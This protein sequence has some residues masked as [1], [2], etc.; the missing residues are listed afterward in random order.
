MELLSNELLVLWGAFL[1]DK[2]LGDPVQLPH[3]IVG[4]GKLIAWFNKKFNK[5]NRRLAKGAAV[6]A[7]LLLATFGSFNFIIQHAYALGNNVGVAVEV[8]CVFFGLAG[9]TLAREGKA[10]FRALHKS[11]DAGRAQVSRIVGRDTSSLSA[12]EVKAA[13]LETLAE[14][15]SDGVIAPLF[16]FTIAGVPGIM[17]Y[18]M[19][20]TLDSMIGYKNEKYL[21][22]GKVAARVDDFANFI[23][24]R[25]TAL[26]MAIC[27]GKKRSFQFIWKYGSAHSSPNAGY[28]E[29]ALAGALH[30]QFGGTHNYFGKPVFKPFIGEKKRS[31]TA[32]DL[33]Q[34][35]RIMRL[36]EFLFMLL[37]SIYF[38]Y[39]YF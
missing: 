1:L 26:L 37:I 32:D 38:K 17:T 36:T 21:L 20:N 28:P 24:A 9:T 23:P 18:K 2:L 33:T 15:L 27:S 13:T 25:I 14:N 35:L 7:F 31:F 34:T 16:W 29:A 6:V 3:P 22:F 8:L 11:L 4:F 19:I 39:I 5:G 10:V 30:A 12:H